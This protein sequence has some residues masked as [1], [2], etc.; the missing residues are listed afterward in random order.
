MN[1]MAG[2]SVLSKT[3]S[4]DNVIQLKAAKLRRNYLG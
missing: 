4:S 2:N 1:D 3:S